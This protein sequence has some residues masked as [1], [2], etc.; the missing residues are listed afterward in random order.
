M[1]LNTYWLEGETVWRLRLG[2]ILGKISFTVRNWTLFSQ[3]TPEYLL[4]VGFLGLSEKGPLSV[5]ISDRG[6]GLLQVI[7]ANFAVQGAATDL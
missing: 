1:I 5:R 7:P 3:S 6:S 4:R 2:R